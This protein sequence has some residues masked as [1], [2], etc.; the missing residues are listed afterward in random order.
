MRG[1]PVQRIRRKSKTASGINLIPEAVFTQLYRR[2][3]ARGI[4]YFLL[5]RRTL[6]WR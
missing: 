1:D 5:S 2:A 6:S 3:I 4:V